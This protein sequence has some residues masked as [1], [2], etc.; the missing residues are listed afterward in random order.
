MI[1]DLKLSIAYGR[2]VVLSLGFLS[3]SHIFIIVMYL[4]MD[5]I[6]I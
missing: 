5:I 6:I 3:D 4:S 1:F 2:L